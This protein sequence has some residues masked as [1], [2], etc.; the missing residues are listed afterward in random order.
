MR[1]RLGLLQDPAVIERQIKREQEEV[2]RK[3]NPDQSPTVKTKEESEAEA[4]ERED[5]RKKLKRGRPIKPLSEAKA[6]DSGATF[7]SE[8]FLFLVAGGLILFEQLRG[9][10]KDNARRDEVK[11]RLDS[12]EEEIVRLKGGSDDALEQ[13]SSASQQ[14]ATDNSSSAKQDST[15]EKQAASKAGAVTTAAAP[16]PTKKDGPSR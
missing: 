15:A 1:M 16:A 5:I 12:L 7:I 6:I 14:S 3:K 11:E 9:K 4:K 2:E 10:R 13:P 8:G